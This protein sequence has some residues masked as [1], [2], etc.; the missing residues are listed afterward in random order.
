MH[1]FLRRSV[2]TVIISGGLA[3]IALELAG[4]AAAVAMVVVAVA[5]SPAA[6]HS[7]RWSAGHGPSTLADVPTQRTSTLTE[8]PTQRTSTPES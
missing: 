2:Q 8:V 6:T 1:P 3:A 7:F 5:G 4:A